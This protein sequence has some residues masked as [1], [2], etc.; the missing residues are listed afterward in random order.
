MSNPAVIKLQRKKI[1]NSTVWLDDNFGEAIHIHIDAIRVDMTNAEFDALYS[2][3][4]DAINELVRVDGFDCH[5]ISPVFLEQMLWKMLPQLEAVKI[6]RVRLKDL[7]CPA[8]DRT[9]VPL[10]ESRC[11]LALS[12]NESS[13]EA[14]ESDLSGQTPQ[15]RLDAVYESIKQNG[16][17]YKNEYIILYGDDNNIIR[18]GQH[19]AACLWKLYGDTEVPVMRLMFRGYT[20]PPEYSWW[21]RNKA[22]LTLGHALR[23]VSSPGRLRA[24]LKRIRKNHRARKQESRRKAYLRSHPDSDRISMIV[25]SK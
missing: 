14:R 24:A 20:T 5:C 23:D 19:R 9:R 21:R 16:Y 2:D 18:D 4:C 3:L 25:E 10:P 17:P 11:V 8:A 15:E 7:V 22:V 13:H 1:S 12:G 6:D